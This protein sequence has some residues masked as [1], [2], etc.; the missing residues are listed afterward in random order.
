MS[1]CLPPPP[2]HT[3]FGTFL[4]HCI[5]WG[6]YSCTKSYVKIDGRL[7]EPFLCENGAWQGGCISHF[8]FAMN[9]NNLEET[10]IVNGIKG[11]DIGM[12]NIFLLFYADDIVL[13]SGKHSLSIFRY[14]V[15]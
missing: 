13:V 3:L 1:V 9:I 5:I 7:S 2:T 15:S 6:L 12:V 14:T 11:I 8:L 10:L 4:R